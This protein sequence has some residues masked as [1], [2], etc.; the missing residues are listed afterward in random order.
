MTVRRRTAGALCLALALAFGSL[1]AGA[2]AQTTDV[3][4]YL[5]EGDASAVHLRVAKEDLLPV[6]DALDTHLPF[7]RARSSSPVTRVAL[8]APAY[9][10]N[11]SNLPDF[12][13]LASGGQFCPP[14][15]PL[16]ASAEQPG[17]TDS[18]E[19]EL[20][21]IEGGPIRIA[22][23]H[24]QVRATPTGAEATATD[25]GFRFAAS[26]GGAQAAS[27]LRSA[28]GGAAPGWSA[29]EE[30]E[31]TLVA[32]G[33]STT[34]VTT[35]VGAGGVVTTAIAEVSGLRLFDG[36]VRIGS[37][38]TEVRVP[39][40][41]EV[42]G[43]PELIGVTVGPFAA[44]IDHRG[45]RIAD[46]DAAPGA[47]Q[48]MN[49]ALA[50]L[51]AVVAVRIGSLELT[52]REGGRTV[53]ASALHLAFRREVV[54]NTGAESGDIAFGLVRA[55]AARFAT[56]LGGTDGDAPLAGF[57]GDDTFTSTILGP[58]DPAT[59][60]TGSLPG[61]RVPDRITA[62]DEP[63]PMGAQPVVDVDVPALPVAVVLL[64]L[65]SVLSATSGIV[66]L[67]GWQ[68]AAAPDWQ[69]TSGDRWRS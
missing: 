24:A 51:D 21:A 16:R 9:D 49:E 57:T 69:L 17:S 60:S 54:P 20:P 18:D 19:T 43:G 7:A 50:A 14:A 37:V 65:L 4:A 11:I 12:M 38:R 31:G 61:P 22:A 5:A 36:Q 66:L 27:A 6:P 55:T 15:L 3:V 1:A 62:L 67:A 26:A 41:G 56:T 44:T 42:S 53:E 45:I 34:H 13:C 30:D 8:A 58:E 63:V 40:G 32:A 47:L 68:V 28:L 64:V 52:P 46:T 23:G 48:R 59:T 39:D 2:M 33:A 29:A 35:Q 10:Q 25:G